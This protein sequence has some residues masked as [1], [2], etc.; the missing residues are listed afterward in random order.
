MPKLTSTYYLCN[1]DNVKIVEFEILFAP[2]NF[3]ITEAIILE[4]S[5]LPEE[6]KDK[7]ICLVLYHFMRNYACDLVDGIQNG[8]EKDA[9]I[10][11][12]LSLGRK[13]LTSGRL[14]GMEYLIAIIQYHCK[15]EE[16]GVYIT[17]KDPLTISFFGIRYG[18]ERLFIEAPLQWEDIEI[19]E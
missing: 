6:F 8:P 5:L 16:Y 11:Q 13:I 9:Y 1:K 15:S 4:E 17:P 19:S 7:D 2:T 10:A 3:A 14:T 18:W 12:R